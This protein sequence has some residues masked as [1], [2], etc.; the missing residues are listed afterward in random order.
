MVTVTAD[1]FEAWRSAARRLVA[2]G[3][4]PADVTWLTSAAEQSTLPFAAT[5][6]LD[7]R[8][9]ATGPAALVPRRFVG[10]AGSAALHRSPRK[11]DGLYRLL[12]RLRSEGS[13]LLDVE[14]DPDVRTVVEMAAQVRRD[15]HKMRAF[16]RFTPVAG[17]DGERYVAW[18]QPDHLIVRAAAPFFTERFASMRWS[19]LTP[20]LSAHWDLR[21]LSFSDGVPLPMAQQAGEID[22]LWRVYYAAVFNPARVN[23]AATL[24]EMP[25]RRWHMLPEASLIPSLVHGAHERTLRAAATRAGASARPWVPDSGN[26]DELRD[27]ARSCRGCSLHG[28]AT[29][30]VFGEGP[31]DASLVLV[32]EQPGDAED[33][34]GRPFVGPAGQVLDTALA[35]AGIDRSRVYLTNAVKHFSFEPRGKRRI[36]QTPRLSEMRACRPWL[37]AELQRI[38]PSTVVC[39]GSTAA[40][41]L[42]GPQARVMALRGRPL[43]GHSWADR[44]IVTVHPSAVLRSEDD[45]RR[46]FEMLVSDLSLAA[47]G[48]QDHVAGEVMHE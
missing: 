16:V 45:G 28:P 8:R 42:L 6:T 22:A 20:D 23:L 3:V 9:D 24:R 15:E 40:R 33:V 19:I 18:Y 35:A 2:G 36:H 25:K 44:V 34:A 26:V 5:E 46:Y 7:T 21:D 29:Q 41:A 11:W 38:R 1:D 31:S 4:P 17:A 32:G 12:W 27:A 13:H 10:L 30:T 14:S 37:E 48:L 47:S 43:E 39:M